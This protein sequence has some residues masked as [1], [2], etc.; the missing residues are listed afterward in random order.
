MLRISLLLEPNELVQEASRVNLKLLAARR[1]KA[2]HEYASDQYKCSNVNLC[3]C[4]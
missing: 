2:K 4:K 1:S 3:K